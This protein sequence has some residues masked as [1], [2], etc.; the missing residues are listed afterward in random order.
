ME[1]L[2]G[3]NVDFEKYKKVDIEELGTEIN[4]DELQLTYSIVYNGISIKYKISPIEILIVSTICSLS[5]KHG[6]CYASQKKFANIFNVSI[7]TIL[8]ALKELEQKGIIRKSEKK[9]QF[10]TLR[11][12]L[13]DEVEKYIKE[14][15]QQIKTSNTDT[16][17]L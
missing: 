11:W 9:S 8:S 4:T 2:N 3:S 16:K 15:R 5:K 13:T 6:Y 17:N 7:P 12:K 1:F 14:I 10:G